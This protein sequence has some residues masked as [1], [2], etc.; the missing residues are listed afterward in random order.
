M[1]FG[2]HAAHESLFWASLGLIA[3]EIVFCAAIWISAEKLER[4]CKALN[5]VAAMKIKRKLTALKALTE[6]ESE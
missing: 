4:R 5:A 2:W 3:F 1:G 6:K